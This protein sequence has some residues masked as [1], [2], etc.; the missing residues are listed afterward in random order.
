MVRANLASFVLAGF[1]FFPQASHLP[2]LVFWQ[3]AEY[4][5]CRL[6]FSLPL[7][8]FALFVVGIGIARVNLHDVMNQQHGHRL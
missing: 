8:L 7:G 6:L 1:E 3:E 5:L 2:A 4:P